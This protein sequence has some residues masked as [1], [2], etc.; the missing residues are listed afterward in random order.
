M[1]LSG[2]GE[3]DAGQP[4]AVGTEDVSDEHTLALREF[5]DAAGVRSPV[6]WNDERRSST[7]VLLDEDHSKRKHQRDFSQTRVVPA[8]PTFQP[9]GGSDANPNPESK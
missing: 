1:V 8:R 9:G 6:E 5:D 4:V 2:C 7:R 3:H